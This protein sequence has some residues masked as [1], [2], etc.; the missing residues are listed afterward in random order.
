MARR[1]INPDGYI[2]FRVNHGFNGRLQAFWEQNRHRFDGSS[3]YQEAR[4]YLF[5]TGLNQTAAEGTRATRVYAERDS[6]L[7]PRQKSIAVVVKPAS[8]PIFDIICAT[9]LSGADRRDVASIVLKVGFDSESP[10]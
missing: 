4:Q 7:N 10:M 8:R 5:D 9:V 3:G 6:F 1:P 2:E